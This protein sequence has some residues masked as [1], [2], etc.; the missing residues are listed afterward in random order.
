MPT[1][2]SRQSRGS[3]VELITSRTNR[4]PVHLSQMGHT[5]YSCEMNAKWTWFTGIATVSALVLGII[6]F[7]ATATLTPRDWVVLLIGIVLGGTL[8]AFIATFLWHKNPKSGARGQFTDSSRAE[9]LKRNIDMW[10][11]ELVDAEGQIDDLHSFSLR[12]LYP[13]A[14]Y[15]RRKAAKLKKAKLTVKQLRENIAEANDLREGLK[16]P[17]P[18]PI[19]ASSPNG[20]AQ[21][22]NTSRR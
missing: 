2:D 3:K 8:A 4:G 12:P 21:K 6:F 18:K 9:E 19:R 14:D 17:T 15:I 20:R 10:E 13:D 7:L 1:T 22:R 16:V 11:Q 5:Q